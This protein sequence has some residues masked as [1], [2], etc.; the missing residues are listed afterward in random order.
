MDRERPSGSVAALALA[1]KCAQ[2][3]QIKGKQEAPSSEAVANKKDIK[4]E[5]ASHQQLRPCLRDSL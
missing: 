5:R 2:N 4:E 3:E 1:Y